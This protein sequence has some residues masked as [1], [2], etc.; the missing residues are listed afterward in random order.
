MSRLKSVL[1]VLRL[2]RLSRLKTVLRVLKLTRLKIK[3]MFRVRILNRRRSFLKS[4]VDERVG[5]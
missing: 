2:K 4:K 5:D 3:K 1:R